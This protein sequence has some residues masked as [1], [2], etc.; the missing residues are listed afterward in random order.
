MLNYAL[1][2]YVHQASPYNGKSFDNCSGDSQLQWVSGIDYSKAF[3]ELY[4][5]LQEMQDIL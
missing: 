3:R 1:L 4:K 5:F 2:Y